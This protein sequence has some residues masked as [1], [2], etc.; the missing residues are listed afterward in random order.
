MVAAVTNFTPR[1]A[2]KAII[3]GAYG[4]VCASVSTSLALKPN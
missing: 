2:C 4:E 3:V 1:I